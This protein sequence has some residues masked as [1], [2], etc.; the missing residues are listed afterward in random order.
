MRW[1][2]L[3]AILDGVLWIANDL[4]GRL[5]PGPDDWEC[6]S[7][8][9]YLTNA[10]DSAAFLIL[11][12]GLVGLH[13]RQAGRYSPLGTAGFFAT[14]VGAAMVGVSNPAEHC[15]ALA[16]LGIVVYTLGVLLLSIGML[17][18]G[19]ATTRARV[20]PRWCGVA[21]IV[22][23]VAMLIGAESGGMVVFGLV[24]IVVRYML[25]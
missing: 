22:G 3:A 6:N 1:G 19:I 11:L 12:L 17:I 20:L 2:G 24:W 25:W 4:G 5:S 16:F 21:L 13:A 8:Y 18:V 9:D 10:I 23:L 14:F 15:L 7:S